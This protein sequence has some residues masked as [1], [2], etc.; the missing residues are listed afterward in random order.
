MHKWKFILLG[1]VILGATAFLAFSSFEE[2]KSYYYNVDE[3]HQLGRKALGMPLKMR[4]MVVPDSLK[5]SGRELSFQMSFGNQT[6]PVT[7]VGNAVIPDN[8]KAGIEVVVSGKMKNRDRFEA[9][10]IQAKCASKYEA[11]YNTLKN[12]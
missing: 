5:R 9:S 12:R 10:H 4:G 7:Y 6:I 1:V 11:D 8:F 2:S 3:V